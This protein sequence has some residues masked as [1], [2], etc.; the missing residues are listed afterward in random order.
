M[1]RERKRLLIA[2]G[3][4]LVLLHTILCALPS[5]ERDPLTISL[6]PDKFLIHLHIFL[7]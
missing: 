5:A 3:F 6:P 1:K 2:C 4:F 7:L